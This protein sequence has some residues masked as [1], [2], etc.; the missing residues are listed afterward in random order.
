M[1][2]YFGYLCEL[3][4]RKLALRGQEES[5]PANCLNRKWYRP[6]YHLE[7]V[8]FE[9]SDLPLGV[10]LHLIKALVIPRPLHWQQFFIRWAFRQVGL[11]PND[12]PFANYQCVRRIL[13]HRVSRFSSSPHG[14]QFMPYLH[15]I[16]T[17]S[18]EILTRKRRRRLQGKGWNE[19]R[20][21]NIDR[22]KKRKR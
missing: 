10:F 12:S 8:M 3:P 21:F 14:S 22:R 11:V 6:F 17:H 9:C 16:I 20:G 19:R 18:G 13:P 5:K 7:R 2:W 15:W 1:G 4:S